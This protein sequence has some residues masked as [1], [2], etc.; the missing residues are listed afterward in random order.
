MEPESW[1][2]WCHDGMIWKINLGLKGLQQKWSQACVCL[3]RGASCV[4][5]SC[6]P[7]G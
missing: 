1:K 7:M 4:P 2:V 5:G 3:C 6:Q